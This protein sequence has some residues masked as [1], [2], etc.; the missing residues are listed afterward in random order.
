MSAVH[1]STA[2]SAPAA[3]AGHRAVSRSFFSESPSHKFTRALLEIQQEGT[4]AVDL[5]AHC[6]QVPRRSTAACC[7]GAVA[8]ACCAGARPL[9]GWACRHTLHGD[10]Q[11]DCG[12]QDVPVAL[13]HPPTGRKGSG[14]G[15]FSGRTVAWR[16]EGGQVV[17]RAAPCAASA[18]LGNV[19]RG[20]RLSQLRSPLSLLPAPPLSSPHHPPTRLSKWNTPWP[21]PT[22]LSSH[23]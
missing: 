13:L 6:S 5:S 8:A 22:R 14:A 16:R 17:G 7:A 19:E 20:A 3:A 12:R 21:V 10:G 23:T 2:S 15:V 9:A 1:A 11:L 18:E 4:L